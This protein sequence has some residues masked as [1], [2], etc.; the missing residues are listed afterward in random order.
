MKRLTQ[1]QHN[2]KEHKLDGFLI[3]S[4][5]NIFYLSG[6]PPLQDAKELTAFITS[7]NLF[8]FV[9][10][11]YKEEASKYIKH[12]TLVELSNHVKLTDL[13]QKIISKENLRCIGFEAYDVTYSFY[14]S[15]K[16]KVQSIDWK[17]I[18]NLIEKQREIKDEGELTSIEKAVHIADQAFSS[19]LAKI[20][21]G[22]L[23]KDI[24]LELEVFLKKNS[25]GIAFSPIVAS[26][27]ASA[28]PHHISG[29]KAIKQG[30]MVLLDFGAKVNGYCSD[31]T[32]TIFIGKAT[33]RFRNVYQ[34][35]LSAQQK[36]LDY[37]RKHYDNIYYHSK[38]DAQILSREVD[39]V[40]RNYIVEKGYPTIP[41]GLGHSLGLEIH[42]SPRLSPSSDEVFKQGM[43]FTIEPGIYIPGWGGVRIED[44][45]VLEKNSIRL[46]T[47][48]TRTL[49]EV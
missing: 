46:L 43:V 16:K 48:A 37:V 23:E 27:H 22:V 33:Q 8:V 20:K 11:T 17:P 10:S 13:V 32:R 15:L 35:V 44:M 40:A 25:D 29:N 12:G 30:E 42:E 7:N 3:T 6:I 31:I 47:Q 39:R 14:S 49:I 36:T 19:I 28:S 4:Q 41:H 18:S 21:P 9:Y 26:G 5:P 38:T 34:T 45:V 24:A 1:I 2:L